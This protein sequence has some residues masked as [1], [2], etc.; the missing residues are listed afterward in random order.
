MGSALF[1]KREP[2]LWKLYMVLDHIRSCTHS[3]SAPSLHRSITPPV[4]AAVHEQPLWLYGCTRFAVAAQN[5]HANMQSSQSEL[6]MRTGTSSST[7]CPSHRTCGPQT[8]QDAEAAQ[9]TQGGAGLGVGLSLQPSQRL[10]VGCLLTGG[11]GCTKLHNGQL[12]VVHRDT[13]CEWRACLRACIPRLQ[14]WLYTAEQKH[15]QLR[16]ML[17]QYNCA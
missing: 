7:A 13:L 3:G 1:R 14:L 15:H 2:W 11:E 6:S 4:W 17:Q 5:R 12:R 8:V 9:E 16:C 10:S